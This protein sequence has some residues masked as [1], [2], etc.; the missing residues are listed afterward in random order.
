MERKRQCLGIFRMWSRAELPAGIG[1]SMI[2][3]LLVWGNRSLPC[4]WIP[5]ER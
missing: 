1:R 2:E 3:N 4:T 5:E